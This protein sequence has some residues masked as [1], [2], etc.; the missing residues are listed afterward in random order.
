MKTSKL[1][2]RLA[3]ATVLGIA[4][5]AASSQYKIY[6]SPSDPNIAGCSDCFLVDKTEKG[7]PFRY[8]I[9]KHTTGGIAGVDE[10][11]TTHQY[12][13]LVFDFIIWAGISYLIVWL[14]IKRK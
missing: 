9:S 11:S 6:S 2:V 10:V 12:T 5:T 8:Q 1:L 7:F 3:G 14:S 13:Y 4:F